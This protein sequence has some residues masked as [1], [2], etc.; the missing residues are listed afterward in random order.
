MEEM[1][2][3]NNFI[4]G[5]ENDEEVALILKRLEDANNGN[6]MTLDESIERF[7]KERNA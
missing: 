2:E 1:L 7:V 4:R 5:K 6:V 3:K